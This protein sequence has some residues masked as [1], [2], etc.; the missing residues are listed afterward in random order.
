MVKILSNKTA[1][2]NKVPNSVK[3]SKNPLDKIDLKLLEG[4]QEGIP[5]F[6]EK[7]KLSIR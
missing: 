4:I 2:L 6:I 1:Y 7:D 3:L 5:L